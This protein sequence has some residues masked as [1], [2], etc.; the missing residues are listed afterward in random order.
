M[1]LHKI[2]KVSLLCIFASIFISASAFQSRVR[3]TPGMHTD[4]ISRLAIDSSEAFIITAGKDKCAILWDARSGKNIRTFFPPQHNASTGNLYAA[5]FSPDASIAAMG[6]ITASGTE[7]Y[8]VY[9]LDPFSGRQTGR[10]GPLTHPVSDLLFTPDGRFLVIS[11]Y[12]GGGVVFQTE[13]WEPV[14]SIQSGTTIFNSA[15]SEKTGIVTASSDGTVTLH[16]RNTFEPRTLLTSARRPYSVAFSPHNEELAV[17]YTGSPHISI[18]ELISG[19]TDLAHERSSTPD[20]LTVVE[21]LDDNHLVS[22]NGRMFS[23]DTPLE[24]SIWRRTPAPKKIV[25]FSAGYGAPTDIIT[26]RTHETII[27]TSLGQ[28]SRITPS[29]AVRYSHTS[30]LLQ[31]SSSFRLSEEADIIDVAVN[32]RWFRLNLSENRLTHQVN[33][34]IY[35]TD[36]SVRKFAGSTSDRGQ[37][38]KVRSHSK[39][40]TIENSQGNIIHKFPVH[41]EI[42]FV[43]VAHATKQIV[44]VHNDGILR[45]YRVSDGKQTLSACIFEEGK[46]W[47]A[48]TPTGYWCG[49]ADGKNLLTLLVDRKEDNIPLAYKF[50]HLDGSFHYPQKIKEASAGII[51]SEKRLHESITP[52]VTI[53]APRQVHSIAD[54]VIIID[55][56]VW[57]P[58]KCSPSDITVTTNGIK[59]QAVLRGLR[60]INDSEIIHSYRVKLL[61]GNNTIEAVAR[62]CNGYGPKATAQTVYRPEKAISY[63]EFLYK[64]RL[65]MLAVGVSRYKNSS[66]DLSYAAK[67]A[68]EFIVSVAPRQTRLYHN[69]ETK[70]YTDNKATRDSILDS[71]QWLSQAAGAQ[72]VTMVFIAGHGVTDS[73][74]RFYFIPHDGSPNRLLSTGISEDELETA[75]AR[76]PGKVICFLDACFAGNFSPPR[77]S[78]SGFIRPLLKQLN[79]AGS[80]IILFSSSMSNQFSEELPRYQNGAFC[81]AVIE[82][83]QGKAD[84][85]GGGYITVNMLETYISR[86]VRELT[87]GRQTPVTTKP[88]GMQDYPIA[89]VNKYH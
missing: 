5:A 77:R 40:L 38:F 25:N 79:H 27:T 34:S 74:S 2:K 57:S 53:D 13:T 89:L 54:S 60:P 58:P 30:P 85:Y 88:P 63:S 7:T 28:L 87:D 83:F 56:S 72:D 84:F 62:N 75:L 44:A 86:R 42:K 82:A 18:V 61:Q 14:A 52:Y 36:K 16:S 43:H 29:G 64:P 35:D 70:T 73:H 48:W 41:S 6:G 55:I 71:F 65:F 68:R 21:W 76:I 47:L 39:L 37:T 10:V 45:W 11:L 66:L 9:L 59:A 78:P 49:T 67:D 4:L 26:T 81:R 1:W 32:N 80:G 46:N 24:I 3:L 15:A 22:A 20:K 23:H 19:N 31:V 12:Y 17:G 69:I 8:W 50:S 33:G 51:H